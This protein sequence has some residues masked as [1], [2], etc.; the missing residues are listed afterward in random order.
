MNQYTSFRKLCYF[1]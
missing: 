1:Q